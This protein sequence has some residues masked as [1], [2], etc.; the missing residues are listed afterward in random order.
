M[1]EHRDTAGQPSS[2]RVDGQDKTDQLT[3]RTTYRQKVSSTAVCLG[4]CTSGLLKCIAETD[5]SLESQQLGPKSQ[6]CSTIEG[7]VAGARAAS[8]RGIEACGLLG[9]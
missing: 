1:D 5:G 4:C 9:P 6:A 8:G 3:Q 7:E 2:P